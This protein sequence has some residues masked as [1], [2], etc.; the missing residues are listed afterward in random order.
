MLGMVYSRL[1]RVTGRPSPILTTQASAPSGTRSEYRR[2]A[3]WR[4][5]AQIT[6]IILYHENNYLHYDDTDI[7]RGCSMAIM[8]I[9]KI[10]LRYFFVPEPMRFPSS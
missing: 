9:R 2:K 8:S 6:S 3:E 7:K 10:P 4:G 1:W 5:M